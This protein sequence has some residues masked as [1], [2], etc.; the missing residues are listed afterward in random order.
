[1]TMSPEEAD[2]AMDAT[3]EEIA[4]AP[5]PEPVFKEPAAM[6][7]LQPAPRPLPA[8][9]PPPQ[10]RQASTTTTWTHH[11]PYSGQRL[12]AQAPVQVPHHPSC[13]KTSSSPH[14]M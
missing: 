11:H 14:V 9:V 2:A 12:R 4:A 1:M 7:P 6:P 5:D 13:A 10:P 8:N 3:I